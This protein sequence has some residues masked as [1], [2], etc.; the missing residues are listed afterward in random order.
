MALGRFEDFAAKTS[1]YAFF[2]KLKNG[3]C[4]HNVNVDRNNHDSQ[5][6][7][8]RQT[9][10]INRE[11]IS[12][13]QKESIQCPISSA[14]I[15]PVEEGQND[16]RYDFLSTP[17]PSYRTENFRVK[18]VYG[19]NTAN[20]SIGRV[21]KKAENKGIFSAKR[22]KLRQWVAEN[23]S[24]D[25]NKLSSKGSDLVSALISRILPEDQKNSSQRAPVPCEDETDLQSKLSSFSEQEDPEF[26]KRRLIDSR[27]LLYLDDGLSR[28]TKRYVDMDLLEWDPT[29][30]AAKSSIQ[31]NGYHTEGYGKKS[32]SFHISYMDDHFSRSKGEHI[33]LDPLEWN[34]K[35]ELMDMD[36]LDWNP[37]GSELSIQHNLCHSEDS[38]KLPNFDM[39]SIL[40][41]DVPLYSY[42]SNN[43]EEL[44]KSYLHNGLKLLEPPRPLL[45]GWDH[46]KE[47]KYQLS[48][49]NLHSEINAISNSQ[50]DDY[51]IFMPNSSMS[52]PPL[53]PY[54]RRHLKKEHFFESSTLPYTPKHLMPVEDYPWR[55]NEFSNETE[56]RRSDPFVYL[57]QSP[58]SNLLSFLNTGLHS[59]A[60][61]YEKEENFLS[62]EHLFSEG[63]VKAYGSSRYM[64]TL[65]DRHFN[66]IKYP[67][68]LDDS[69]LN[70]EL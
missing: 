48:P 54:I 3:T 57:T 30:Q 38:F 41:F 17:A 43:P 26:Y 20:L 14:Q 68:L 58:A 61:N 70:D 19:A 63:R 10:H 15:H 12:H 8:D 47:E 52:S 9:D 66:H 59:F 64:E 16:T 62:P 13:V 24:Y 25:V 31:D 5:L 53:S 37:R 67:S 11:E 69:S 28:S 4:S 44:D 35:R 18:N 50:N 56:N 29:G 21:A 49:L 51:Q 7:S 27:H 22:E 2:K 65:E 32:S 55:M 45:L 33:N 46:G 36:R 23:S 40:S 39:E 1:E 34:S 6:K 60:V 42:E